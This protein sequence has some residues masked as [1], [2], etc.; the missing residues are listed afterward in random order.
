[1][2]IKNKLGIKTL[3]YPLWLSIITFLLTVLCPV[4][5]ILVEGLK[6]PNTKFGVAFKISF[7]IFGGLV[8][9]WFFVKKLIIDKIQQ[10]LV[11]KQVALEHDYS[12]DNGNPLKIKYLWYHNQLIMLIFSLLSTVLYGGLGVIILLGV[13][14]TVLHVKNLLILIISLY[15]IN[16]SIRFMY[17]SI[18]K[19]LDEDWQN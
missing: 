7:V 11:L 14:T 12:I 2:S 3:K 17:I 10:K 13:S 16:Y 18:K 19:G 8:I 6:A 1:M 5:V 15:I 9:A 4:I